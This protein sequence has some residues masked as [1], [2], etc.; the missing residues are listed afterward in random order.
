MPD[1]SK[2]TQNDVRKI[3]NLSKLS[4]TKEETELFTGQFNDILE[5]MNQLNAID[6]GHVA[7]LRH[8][9]DD[10]QPMRT[11]TPEES[12]TQE[13]ALDRAPEKRDHYFKVPLVVKKGGRES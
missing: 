8:V 12:F 11:D 4:L 3:A 13:R 9:H 2:I 7:P 5:Y 10:M 1:S 6:T